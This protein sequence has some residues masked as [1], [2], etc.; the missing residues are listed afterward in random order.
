MNDEISGEREL[1]SLAD[2]CR[3]FALPGMGVRIRDAVP[4]LMVTPSPTIADGSPV[5]VPL[6]PLAG[7]YWLGRCRWE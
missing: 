6:D 2:L 4:A 7:S 3:S 5:H 1:G